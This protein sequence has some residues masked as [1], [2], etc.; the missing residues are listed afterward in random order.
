MLLL[1]FG[2]VGGGMGSFSPWSGPLSR[3]EHGADV[4]FR[5]GNLEG[6]FIEEH[7]VRRSRKQRGSPSPE[8]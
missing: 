6:F 7:L 2:S 5:S 1:S 8:L 4:G 3:G